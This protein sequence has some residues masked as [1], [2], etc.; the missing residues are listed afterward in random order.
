V[1]QLEHI[2]GTLEFKHLYRSSVG[3]FCQF[4]SNQI[5]FI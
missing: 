1:K 4:K 5:K 2:G 3:T